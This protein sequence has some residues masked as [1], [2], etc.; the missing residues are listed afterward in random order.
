MTL[1]R[2]PAKLACLNALSRGELEHSPDGW[3]SVRGLDGLWNSHTGGFRTLRLYRERAPITKRRLRCLIPPWRRR[4]RSYR[5]EYAL[6]GRAEAGQEKATTSRSTPV[7]G[8]WHV[9][10]FC[11]RAPPLRRRRAWRVCRD[12]RGPL[13]LASTSASS[14]QN[15]T[16]DCSSGALTLALLTALEHEARETFKYRDVAVFGPHFNIERLVA[17]AND[18]NALDERAPPQ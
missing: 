14:S 7:R 2:N 15:R 12:G 16:G 1:D 13:A 3:R 4:S 6:V 18:P 10:C 5:R 17:L 9:P 11:A 8:Y